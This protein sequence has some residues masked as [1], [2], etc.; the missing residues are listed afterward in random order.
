MVARL[1]GKLS[2]AAKSIVRYAD[3]EQFDHEDGL[4]QFLALLRESPLQRLPVPDSF[5]RLDKWSNLKRTDRETVAELI[6]REEELFTELQQSLA[7]A[8]LD[9]M[10]PG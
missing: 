8:R 4:N 6:V 10:S 1:W 7:R 3:P 9:R 2:G 5:N